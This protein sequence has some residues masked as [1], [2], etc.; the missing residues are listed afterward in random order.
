[1]GIPLLWPF[2]SKYLCDGAIKKGMGFGN[3]TTF[4]SGGAPIAPVIRQTFASLNMPILDAYGLS[5]TSGLFC[6]SRMNN[7][8]AGAVGPIVVGSECLIDHNDD[9]DEEN[10]GEI[11]YRGRLAMMGYVNE[12]K[13]TT[14][15]FDDDGWFH[16]GDIGYMDEYDC[17]HITGRIKELLVTAGGEN[18]APVPV[19]T[20]IKKRLPALSQAIMIGDKKKYC[21]I[22]VSIACEEDANGNPTS[23]LQAHAKEVNPSIGTVEEAIND[24]VWHEYLRAGIKEYNANKKIC[25]SNSSKI[26][27]FQILHK[28]LSVA[29]GTMSASMKV[30]RHKLAEVY[31][32]EMDALYGDDA[33]QPSIAVN[34][35]K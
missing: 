10:Q 25:V 2:V 32:K 3:C 19:E 21:S 13:K 14:A 18:V 33:A 27:Y 8:V 22:L 26:Q 16:T 24:S 5:E 23:E 29:D 28:D 17:L 34:P 31:Q 4:A 9:R 20:F 35:R 12:P 30:K 7:Y 11:C 15:T 6:M 1:M